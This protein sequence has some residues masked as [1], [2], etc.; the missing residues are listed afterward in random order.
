MT[1]VSMDD[2]PAIKRAFDAGL[3]AYRS[4]DAAEA[5]QHLVPL[6]RDGFADAQLL[7]GVMAVDFDQNYSEAARWLHKAAEQNVGTAQ[8]YLGVMYHSGEGVERNEA[9]SRYWH[10]QANHN[11]A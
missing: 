2:L 11:G 8:R 9:T 7:M 5:R 1:Y 10:E 4:N 3:E 6:A